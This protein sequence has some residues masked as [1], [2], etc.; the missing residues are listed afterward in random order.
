MIRTVLIEDEGPALKNLMELLSD[1]KD[2]KVEAVIDSIQEGIEYFSL[3]KN[4][5]LI[6][7]DV[8]LTD[9][10]S[11]EI[12]EK[13]N[14]QAPVIFVTAY[15]KF[16]TDIFEYN[17]IDYL[18]KPVTAPD[19]NKA[20]QK[21]KNLQNHFSSNDGLKQLSR[22]FLNKEKRILVRKGIEYIPLL[23]QDIVLFFT[24]NK[25]VYVLDKTGKKFIHDKNLSELESGLDPEI[26]FRA[27]RKYIVNLDYIKGFKSYEKVKLQLNLQPPFDEQFII[28]SQE[29]APFFKKWVVGSL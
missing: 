23:P 9:G 26:F 25:I 1:E 16:I 6:F 11:F 3:E 2:I 20:I 13:V 22:L 29:N 12:F 14:I 4:I 7:S 27:N 28:V 15:N 24:E 5:D 8:Q 18:L 19:I 21:Y 17:S 10:L